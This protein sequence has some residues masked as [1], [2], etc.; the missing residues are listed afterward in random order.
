MSGVIHPGALDLR[1]EGRRD[2][3]LGV[4]GSRAYKTRLLQT[5]VTGLFAKISLC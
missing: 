4:N 2:I 3:Y 5:A 1:T